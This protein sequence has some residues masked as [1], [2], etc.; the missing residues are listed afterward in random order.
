M[1]TTH[2]T[3]LLTLFSSTCLLA[4]SAVADIQEIPPEEMTEAYIRDT[5]VVVPQQ[6]QNSSATAATVKVAPL[7]D[8][9]GSNQA[10]PGDDRSARPDLTPAA[11][12]YLSEQRDRQLQQQQQ[13]GIT[14]PQPTDAN[15]AAREAYLRD[16]LGL[17]AGQPIDYNNLKF[18]MPST[19]PPVPTGLTGYELKADQFSIRIPNTNDHP[20]LTQQTP[21]GEM[22]VDVT[23]LDII[24]TINLPQ[25]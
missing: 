12:Q 21:G 2:R 3:F 15:I 17:K 24:F 6:N 4:A 13:P 20:A 18:P 1:N 22:K 14:Q 7:E 19:L 8:L 5:T 23:P 25:R 11:E 16:L 9:P 10:T